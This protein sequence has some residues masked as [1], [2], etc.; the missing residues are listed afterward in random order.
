MMDYFQITW[1]KN[2]DEIKSNEDIVMTSE[3]KQY[4][5]SIRNCC[6]RDDYSLIVAQVMRALTIVEMNAIYQALFSFISF[7]FR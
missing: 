7:D 5:L 1:F 6:L 4:T 3:G 2:G